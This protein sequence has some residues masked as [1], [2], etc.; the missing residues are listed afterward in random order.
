MFRN[1][2]VGGI[3]IT[4][5]IVKTTSVDCNI[6][7]NSVEKLCRQNL[8]GTNNPTS[9]SGLGNRSPSPSLR[10]IDKETK[11]GIH[12]LYNRT[13]IEGQNDMIKRFPRIYDT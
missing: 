8:I 7:N 10:T 2:G 5:R 11:S 4:I 6:I 3:T 9:I 13:L 12:S 1:L